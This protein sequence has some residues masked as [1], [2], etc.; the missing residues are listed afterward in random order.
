MVWY[1]VL[2]INTKLILRLSIYIIAMIIIIKLINMSISLHNYIVCIY[3]IYYLL[4]LR[5]KEMIQCVCDPKGLST[6]EAK[7][8]RI[9]KS[10]RLSW[11][12]CWK[13]GMVLSYLL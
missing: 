1:L 8:K 13:K 10:L 12:L 5:C 9:S 2:N 7:A 3:Y 4:L 6:W 11:A